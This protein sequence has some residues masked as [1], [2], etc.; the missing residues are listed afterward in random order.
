MWVVRLNFLAILERDGVVTN[1]ALESDPARDQ[2]AICTD[3]ADDFR[4][5]KDKSL[6]V[7][8]ALLVP[9]SSA[10]GYYAKRKKKDDTD[11]PSAGS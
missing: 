8:L 4:N 6:E 11:R 1:K 5:A 3:L 7:V 2:L 10:I 9:T